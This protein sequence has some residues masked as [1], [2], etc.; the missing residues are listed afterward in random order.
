MRVPRLSQKRLL[1]KRKGAVWAC[2]LATAIAV[3][4][5]AAP[6]PATSQDLDHATFG[7]FLAVCNTDVQ[8]CDTFIADTD[9]MLFWLEDS[10]CW[11]EGTTFATAKAWLFDWAARH[12]ETHQLSAGAAVE[13]ALME[14]FPCS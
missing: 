11:P 9:E 2:L 1:Q 14:L 4:A 3:L 5:V 10:Y 6:S 7:Q 12:P 13:R 8:S